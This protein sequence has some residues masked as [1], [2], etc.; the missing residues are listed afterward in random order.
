MASIFDACRDVDAREAARRLNIRIARGGR[1]ICPFCGHDPPTLSFS[2]RLWHCYCCGAAGDAIKLY[3]L[4]HSIPPLEAARLINREFDCGWQD[5]GVP[6]PEAK[7]RMEAAQ[8]RRER[9]EEDLRAK[10]KALETVIWAEGYL[11]A[12]APASPD[13]MSAEFMLILNEACLFDLIWS[14]A[15]ERERSMGALARGEVMALDAIRQ[16]I[17]GSG[18]MDSDKPGDGGSAGHNR[19]YSPRRTHCLRYPF[20][21]PGALTGHGPAQDCRAPLPRRDRDAKGAGG[22]SAAGEAAQAADHLQ[23]NDVFGP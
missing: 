3:E 1:G 22:R 7:A 6:T 8:V 18:A 17:T 23:A 9:E 11:S 10:R 14:E 5:S 2:G 13:D 21:R 15:T 19:A 16:Y 4:Y 12:H 20:Q